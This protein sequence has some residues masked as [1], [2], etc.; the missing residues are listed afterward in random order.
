MKVLSNTELEEHQQA[1]EVLQRECR[2]LLMA[3]LSPQGLPEMSYA[4]YAAGEGCYYVFISELAAHTRNLLASSELSVLFI[5]DEQACRNLF[6]RE[7]LSWRC[8]ARE[9]LPG[10]EY[11]QG[12]ERLE[13][14]QGQMIA[15]LRGLSDFR[16][17]A[18][19]PQQ[20]T[21]VV[22]FGK[23]FEVDASTGQL[24]H[25]DEAAVKAGSR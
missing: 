10:E 3:T 9:V 6:A 24:I 17:F 21:Y 1:M 12:L 13:A 5:R 2:T 18:L 20:G 4:P 8:H 15:M 11:E 16:L 22:G 25:I 19:E 23:A 7:R 14:A